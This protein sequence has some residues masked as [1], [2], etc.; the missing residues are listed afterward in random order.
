MASKPKKSKR[1]N[2]NLTAVLKVR[3]IREKQRQEAFMEAQRE[4]EEEQKKE[5]ELKQ[6]IADKYQEL[7]EVLTGKRPSTDIAGE[8]IQRK[9]NLESLNEKLAEQIQKRE[10]AEKKVDE[11]REELIKAVKDKKIIE[12]DKEHK[13]VAWQKLMIKED[14]KFM[15]DIST[16]GFDRKRRKAEALEEQE[17]QAD[18][19]KFAA[20]NAAESN[21]FKLN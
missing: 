13:R 8:V 12:K 11:A 3:E 9:T 17:D 16:V 15:D 20:E 14:N 6:N 18:A 7:R 1:F 5:A 21:P 4:L 2:Y 10:E 19:K